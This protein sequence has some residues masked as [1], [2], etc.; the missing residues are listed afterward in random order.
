[1]GDGRPTQVTISE[2]VDAMNSLILNNRRISAKNVSRDPDDI[3]RKRG[4][5]IHEKLL[6]F[7]REFLLLK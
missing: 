6:R 3:Q 5:I 7:G 2:N 1:M 4:Y